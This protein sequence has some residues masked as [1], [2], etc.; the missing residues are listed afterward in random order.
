MDGEAKITVNNDV[1]VLRG[2]K[3][4]FSEIA[5]LNAKIKDERELLTGRGTP[6]SDMPRGH[7]EP[8]DTYDAL[9]AI[10]QLKAERNG[11]IRAYTDQVLE[12]ERILAGVQD[13]TLRMMY[14]YLFVE[15]MPEWMVAKE[16]DL[17]ERTVRYKKAKAESAM[18]LCNVS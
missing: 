15:N 3:M 10:E 5:Y 14:R 2:C 8:H 17:S 1:R 13:V 16:V 6:I 4:L 11:K 7:G 18:E 9:D 12:A